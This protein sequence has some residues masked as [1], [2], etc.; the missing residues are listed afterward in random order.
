MTTLLLTA[1][2]ISFVYA[3]YI[4]AASASALQRPSD[5]LDGGMLIPA[6][7]YILGGAG[8]VVAALGLED[9]LLLIATYGLQYNHVALG[10]ILAALTGTLVH[11][12]LWLT[13]RLTGM[14]T[15][16]Q[17]LGTYYA[18]TT[19]RLYVLL[20]VG[21]FALPFAAS[22]LA[23]TGALLEQATGGALPRSEERRVG[24]ECA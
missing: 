17:L 12:Q 9:H 24:K 23:E 21:L 13:A 3:V 2:G 19:I 1:L 11:K 22:L 18:S 7:G 20:V 16:G 15:A 5:F 6:W 10:L 4:A 14:R 8:V